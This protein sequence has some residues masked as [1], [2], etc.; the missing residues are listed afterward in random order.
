MRAL[1][2]VLVIPY[3]RTKA[4]FEFAILKRSDTKYWQFIAGGGEDNETPVQAAERE[5]KEEIGIEVT[6]Q[7]L[8][9]DSIA[10]IPRDSFAGSDAWGPEVDEIPEYA[11]AIDVGN[12]Q[13]K[14]SNE[15]TEYQWV[16][17]NEAYTF[18]YWDSNRDALQKLNEWLKKILS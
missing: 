12:N 10:A 13:I 1:F 15:H 4:G 2:Q 11:F 6:G 5:T 9:L 14:L 18:L 3:R 8:Q 7:L 16:N 17:F